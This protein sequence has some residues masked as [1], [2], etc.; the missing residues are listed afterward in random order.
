M[1]RN[2]IHCIL[3]ALSCTLALS[4]VKDIVQTPEPEEIEQ[5]IT[6]GFETN[7]ST[8]TSL[9]MNEEGTN[10]SVLWTRGDRFNI[11][12]QTGA[13]TSYGTTFRT[14]D[15]GPVA[16]FTGSFNK[17][18][19]FFCIYPAA[20]AHGVI[21]VKDGAISADGS[22]VMIASIPSQQNAV[23][24]GIE[25]G[26]NVSVAYATTISERMTFRNIL[27]YIHFRITGD[28]AD[29]VVSIEL[30]AGTKII[31]GDAMVYG[32]PDGDAAARFDVNIT[33]LF[34]AR[35]NEVTLNGPFTSGQDYYIAL[36]PVSLEGFRMTFEDE[37][38]H[39]I[40]KRSTLHLDFERSHVY[41][42]GT[43]DLGDS[44]PTED[45]GEKVT[46][47]MTASAG[48]KPVDLCVISEGFKKDSLEIY[49]SLAESAIDLLFQTEPYKTYRDYFN[50]YILSVPS[51]ESGASITDGD[52][53]I[54]TDRDTYFKA[55]W[56]E[57]AYADMVAN[58]EK[59]YSYVS[60]H[61]PDIVSG[62]HTIQEVP[63]L[64]I[65]NDTRYGGICHS[66][67]DGRSY[68]MV[69]YTYR[70]ASITWNFPNIVPKTDD[71][72]PTPVTTET[73]R[74]YYRNPTS[75]EIN[76]MGRSIGDW[77][78]TVIHEFGGHGFGRLADEYWPNGK[79]AYTDGPV[80]GQ[81]YPVPFGLN[82]AN[83][84]AAVPWASDLLE[85]LE[86]L[87]A[88][89]PHYARIGVY[90]GG[91]TYLYGRW[92]S[93]KISCMID[94]RCYF[95]AWQRELIVKRIMSLAGLPFTWEEF[96]SRDVTDDPVRD[97]P[98][99][100][101]SSVK[102]DGKQPVYGPPLPPPVLYRVE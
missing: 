2:F 23:A 5:T 91:D 87:T 30:D 16:S 72:L 26:L 80:S 60:K 12:V 29:S 41:D 25:E 22:P 64:M 88:L 86:E 76:E 11:Y 39:R 9:S 51:E 84:P 40:I 42:F 6:A 32:T 69:P 100:G 73:L 45:S 65:I 33:Q 74:Q 67:S 85:R 8:R 46:Q 99:A 34:E 53:T 70:G 7:A 38:G 66:I 59:V 36:A 101:T 81:D 3:I 21:S 78:N 95:S 37:A 82:I 55:R 77:R 63:I 75:Q 96:L 61:C 31:A 47:Y 44:F 19:P 97:N 83:N 68:A 54:V 4:C 18:G 28:A 27:S 92:R 90:Q 98:P 13:S 43:I 48:Q 93:E 10:V 49:Q 52:G 71:P 20:K 57:G 50:V 14:N 1:R 35:S 79:L 15:S 94:N 58:G 17:A 56:A 102:A 24:G 89:D 62:T